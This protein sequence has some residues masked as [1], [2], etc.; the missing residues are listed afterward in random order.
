MTPEQEKM[1]EDYAK[2]VGIH[3]L[4]YGDGNNAKPE[5]KAE[6]NVGDLVLHREKER[7]GRVT[8]YCPSP[9]WLHVRTA[10]GRYRIWEVQKLDIFKLEKLGIQT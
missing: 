7:W 2:R 3:H 10:D 4:L 1:L 6:P 5:A 9:K 8:G